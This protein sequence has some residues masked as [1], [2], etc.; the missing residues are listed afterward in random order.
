MGPIYADAKERGAHYVAEMARIRY[1]REIGALCSRA[2][3]EGA[4]A[5]ILARMRTTIAG[6]AER[7]APEIVAMSAEDEI[8]QFILAQH[9]RALE[10]VAHELLALTQ[11]AAA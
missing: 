5:D 3:V 11:P 4:L 6:L 8:R 2:E 10:D 1:E 9:A 7:M